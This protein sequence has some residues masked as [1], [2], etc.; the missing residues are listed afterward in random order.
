MAVEH[1]WAY[2]N[3]TGPAYVSATHERTARIPHG[4][5]SLEK[6][7]WS[8][9]KSGSR[10]PM[11]HVVLKT[12]TT[13]FKYKNKADAT[14]GGPGESLSHRLFKEAISRITG[15]QL[16]LK[17]F[18]EHQIQI[19]A[20]ATE[21][22]IV[23]DDGKYFA[24][25]Y[26]RFTSATNLALRWE[27]EVYVEVHHK[28]AVPVEKQR[29][30][31]ELGIPVVE[32]K[33]PEFFEY[34]HESDSTAKHEEEHVAWICRTL[35]QGGFLAGTVISDRRSKELL[36]EMVREL[37]Q[38]L[39]AA[40]ADRKEMQDAYK[41]RLEK[42]E[43]EVARL[44]QDTVNQRT[45]ANQLVTRVANQEGELTDARESLKATKDN[46]AAAKSGAAKASELAAAASAEL[47]ALRKKLRFRLLV[48]GVV[49]AGV[50]CAFIA[51]YFFG[52]GSSQA[53]AT[54]PPQAAA[55]TLAP[56]PSSPRV[57]LVKSQKRPARH[58]ARRATN[59]QSLGGQS[60]D[61]SSES[62]GSDDGE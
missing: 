9:H 35:Q 12:G 17:N 59:E 41:K 26:L 14:K 3:K 23:F 8:A 49:F 46:L 18:G 44:T 7:Y 42:A 19:Q 43:E 47:T 36:E 15:T 54:T 52:S 22:E 39:L 50:A 5:K 2:V 11:E 61:G 1:P 27:G 24:D 4:G 32:V 16:K 21:K 40:N 37:E 48:G 45:R 10:W 6:T 38:Q 29:Q 62:H 28:H 34:R 20:G 56:V 57:A 58:T 51:F 13:F 33:L 30:L 25:A 53:Q 55:P 60:F 31:R